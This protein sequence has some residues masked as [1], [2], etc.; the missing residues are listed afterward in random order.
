MSECLLYLLLQENAT[1]QELLTSDQMRVFLPFLRFCNSLIVAGTDL[2][3][4][5]ARSAR[6]HGGRTSSSSPTGESAA[7]ESSAS[8]RRRSPTHSHASSSGS[9]VPDGVSSP[10][11]TLS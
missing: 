1:A 7:S 5:I 11:G 9:P 8:E 4:S 2:Y 10:T 3:W 6:G